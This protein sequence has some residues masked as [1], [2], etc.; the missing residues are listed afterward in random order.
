MCGFFFFFYF[1]R[2]PATILTCFFWRYLKKASCR[3]LPTC[4]VKGTSKTT[5]DILHVL[6]LKFTLRSN[7]VTCAHFL[8]KFEMGTVRSKEW[9]SISDHQDDENLHEDPRS[10]TNE[11][12]RTPIRLDEQKIAVDPRSPSGIDRTPILV[13]PTQ[14]ENSPLSRTEKKNASTDAQTSRDV[15]Q[16]WQNSAPPK[17]ILFEKRSGREPLCEKN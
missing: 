4:D 9:T 6:L 13:P 17:K 10:P 12:T 11:I 2:R 5:S 15:Y 3:L 14:K 1:S 16:E 8:K 7:F